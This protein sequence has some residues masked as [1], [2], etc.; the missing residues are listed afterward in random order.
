MS[1]FSGKCDFYDGFVAISCNGD[2]K[3]IKQNLNKLKLYVYGKD[4]RGHLVKSDTIKDIVKY[5]PYI[6]GL[7]YQDGR[8]RVVHLSSDSF[9]DREERENIGYYIDDVR[10]YRNRCKRKKEE[11]TVEKCVERFSMWGNQKLYKEIATRYIN[12]GN[13]AEFDD[14]HD[15]LHEHYRRIWFDE[16]VRVGYTEQEAYDWCFKGR[17]DDEETVIKRLGRPLKNEVQPG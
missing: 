9:I 7:V 10:K 2:D 16:M 13:K 4:D 3:L 1:Q 12:Y 15:Y 5:Y 11:F 8:K 14:I 6:E 17:F